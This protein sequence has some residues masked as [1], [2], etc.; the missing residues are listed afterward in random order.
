VKKG[1]WRKERMEKD[2]ERGRDQ[3]VWY[4]SLE[5]Y[6]MRGTSWK[7]HKQGLRSSIL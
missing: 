4:K 3:G 2:R 7:T 5:Y 6:E 1:R